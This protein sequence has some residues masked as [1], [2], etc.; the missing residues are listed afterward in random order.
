[1]AGSVY[2][3]ARERNGNAYLKASSHDDGVQLGVEVQADAKSELVL[4]WRW[5]VW[6]VPAGGDERRVE[7]MDSAA[8]VYAVFGSRL[9]PRVIKDVW[10]TL[11]PA[12]TVLHHPA[13]GEWASS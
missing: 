13:P 11:V 2:S 7:T 5:R 3:I 12:G 8:A 4:G 1:M 9:L 6:E 10:S